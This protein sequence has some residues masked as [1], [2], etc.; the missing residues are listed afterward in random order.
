MVPIGGSRC[1]SAAHRPHCPPAHDH[2]AI[3]DRYIQ[4]GE[5]CYSRRGERRHRI[6]NGLGG[7]LNLESSRPAP[8][9]TCLRAYM[10]E[11][12]REEIERYLRGT[13]GTQVS[14]VNLVALGGSSQGKDIKGCGYGT[15]VRVDY[16][17]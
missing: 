11:L 6:C 7:R 15:P 13:F 10:V 14:V 8:A 3:Q 1:G 12:K 17:V 9:V 4:S 2:D 16:R 5:C